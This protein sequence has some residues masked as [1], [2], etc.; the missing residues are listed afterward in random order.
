MTHPMICS[1]FIDILCLVGLT[2]LTLA[3]HNRCDGYTCERAKMHNYQLTRI[4]LITSID[5]CMTKCCQNHLCNAFEWVDSS[6]DCYVSLT[7]LQQIDLDYNYDVLSCVLRTFKGTRTIPSHG[8]GL[9]GLCG[10]LGCR[11]HVASLWKDYFTSSNETYREHC[12]QRCCDDNLC[13]SFYWYEKS[14]KCLLSKSNLL[15]STNLKSDFNIESDI[16][17]LY[18]DG[19]PDQPVDYPP[20]AIP[21]MTIIALLVFGCGIGFFIRHR[22]RKA[23]LRQNL[24]QSNGSMPPG[25]NPDRPQQVSV[26]RHTSDSGLRSNVLFGN[27]VRRESETNIVGRTLDFPGGNLNAR[28]MNI[29]PPIVTGVSQVYPSHLPP[30]YM[31]HPHGMTNMIHPP[32]NNMGYDVNGEAPPSYEIAILE[33]CNQ[34]NVS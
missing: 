22:L 16:C 15:D 23:H 26:T 8:P 11:H 29:H 6:K 10:G 1:W 2:S 14:K 30:P 17:T 25:Q 12:S 13:N 33:Q 27:G 5:G 7:L 32:H 4:P 9:T 24:T 34:N 3:D 18:R 19:F 28:S 20:Y 21:M 31:P